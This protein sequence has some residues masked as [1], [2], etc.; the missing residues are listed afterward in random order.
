MVLGKLLNFYGW[1]FDEKVY[2]IDLRD[3]NQI[4]YEK[5]SS[6]EENSFANLQIK[7]PLNEGKVMTKNCYEFDKVKN[8]FREIYKYCFV[9]KEN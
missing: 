6:G 7:D 1:E 4:Y 8:I 9:E 3:K 2:G 5:G